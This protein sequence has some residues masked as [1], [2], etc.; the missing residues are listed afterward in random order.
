MPGDLMLR[1]VAT[2]DVYVMGFITMPLAASSCA[3][4]SVTVVHTGASEVRVVP[5][6][7]YVKDVGEP[8]ELN[9]IDV[10]IVGDQ[11]LG[12]IRHGQGLARNNGIV[13]SLPGYRSPQCRG[14]RQCT[15]VDADVGQHPR[16]A[17]GSV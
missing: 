8:H 5:L 14:T 12:W 17:R 13:G 2:F 11:T 3:A 16:V 15:A 7:Q 9:A 4:P 10:R 1:E 6:A